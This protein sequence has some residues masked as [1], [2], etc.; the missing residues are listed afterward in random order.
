MTD[1]RSYCDLFVGT[2][3]NKTL[4]GCCCFAVVQVSASQRGFQGEC[5]NPS[6]ESGLGDKKGGL[7]PCILRAGLVS[8]EV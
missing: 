5:A 2:R 8:V 4:P 1:F 6:E 7:L 3:G